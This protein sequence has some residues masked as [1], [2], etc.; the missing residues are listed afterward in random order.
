MP[1]TDF[2]ASLTKPVQF[3]LLCAALAGEICMFMT[4]MCFS[5][6]LTTHLMFSLAAVFVL[7]ANLVIDEP[8]SL[9]LYWLKLCVSIREGKILGRCS[10]FEVHYLLV[11][12][13]KNWLHY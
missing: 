13:F 6:V 8:Y 2:T 11:Q 9:L 3:S 1:R 4:F 7:V 12:C 5:S 10:M